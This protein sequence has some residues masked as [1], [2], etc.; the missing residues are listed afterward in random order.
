MVTKNFLDFMDQMGILEMQRN[1][2]LFHTH[3][4]NVCMMDRQKEWR[5]LLDFMILFGLLY[6]IRLMEVSRT[7]GGICSM[8]M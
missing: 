7:V 5:K 4:R 2:G 6:V 3:V 1:V 8:H